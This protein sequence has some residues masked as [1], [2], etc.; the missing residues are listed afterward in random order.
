M[1]LTLTYYYGK[2]KYL[3][4]HYFGLQCFRVFG[5]NIYF[6]RECTRPIRLYFVP[7]IGE[8]QKKLSPKNILRRR[9]KKS[10]IRTFIKENFYSTVL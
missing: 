1:K 3:Q 8:G 5:Q 7:S 9:A 4:H 6:Y 2:I 10:F